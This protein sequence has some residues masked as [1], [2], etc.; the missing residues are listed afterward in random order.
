[1]VFF[2]NGKKKEKPLELIKWLFFYL[3]KLDKIKTMTEVVAKNEQETRKLAKLLAEEIIKKPLKIKTALVIGLKG[4]LGSRKTTFIK[5]FSRKLGIR[6]RLSSS[7]FVILKRYSIK[8][9]QF[10]NLYHIDCYRLYKPKEL[11]DLDLK[12]I[13]SNPQNIVLVEWAEKIRSVLPKGTIWIRF[14]IV[15]VKERRLV[16]NY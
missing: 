12:E 13:I 1:M 7:T 16:V 15:G 2:K 4:E 14:K 6:K 8:D 11:L 10:A 3:P 5:A 9:K